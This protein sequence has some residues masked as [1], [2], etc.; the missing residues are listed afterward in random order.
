VEDWPQERRQTISMRASLAVGLLALGCGAIP[1]VGHV[2]NVRFMSVAVGHGFV[3]AADHERSVWCWG[4]SAPFGERAAEYWV[5][6]R[7]PE[8]GE[9]V[10][11]HASPSRLC[12]TRADGDVECTGGRNS[13]AP[14]GCNEDVAIDIGATGRVAGVGGATELRMSDATVCGRVNG[15]WVCDTLAS[16]SLGAACPL[17]DDPAFGVDALDVSLFDGLICA[18][19]PLDGGVECWGN[20]YL[21]VLGG[22][23]GERCVPPPGVRLGSGAEHVRVGGNLA[24]HWADAGPL[25]CWGGLGGINHDQG[26]RVVLS[27]GLVNVELSASQILISDVSGAVR[28]VGFDGGMYNRVALPPSVEQW[29]VGGC[30]TACGIREGR[31]WCYSTN[32]HGELGESGRSRGWRLREVQWEPNHG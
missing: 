30:H 23:E 32:A 25:T 21:G 6:R 9:A 19:R 22:G 14:V 3:C 1:R 2:P 29:A 11:V 24:C 5:P 31:V 8:L 27:S 18:V 10:L 28:D 4:R 7:V 16:A 17:S 20:G 12:I 15:A 26:P 13:T